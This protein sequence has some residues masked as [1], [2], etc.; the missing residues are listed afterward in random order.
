[1]SKQPPPAPTTSAVGPCPTVNQIVGR[2]GTAKSDFTYL[3]P[4]KNNKRARMDLG[5]SPEHHWNQIISKFVH[6]F[7][8][9]S[10]LKLYFLFIALAAILFNRAERF[11][12][13]L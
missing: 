4:A 2:P 1:M 9:R 12:Q 6:R 3:L 5:R 8:R 13:F 10:R 11:E 7:S